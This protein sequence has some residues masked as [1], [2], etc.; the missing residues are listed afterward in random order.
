MKVAN[1]E[2]DIEVR[3]LTLMHWGKTKRPKPNAEM[4]KLGHFVR[5]ETYT[6]LS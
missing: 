2:F 3:F 5:E 1:A 4:E 6:I